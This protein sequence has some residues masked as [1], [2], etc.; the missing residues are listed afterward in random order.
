MQIDLAKAEGRATAA[1]KRL[2]RSFPLKYQELVQELSDWSE[3]QLH[4]QLEKEISL[5]QKTHHEE[6]KVEIE[7]RARQPEFESY[8]YE[9]TEKNIPGRNLNNSKNSFQPIYLPKLDTV[10]YS[11]GGR[12]FGHILHSGMNAELSGSYYSFDTVSFR[13]QDEKFIFQTGNRITI[14]DPYNV[15]PPEQKEIKTLVPDRYKGLPFKSMT[16]SH[17]AETG[18]LMNGHFISVVDLKNFTE[19]LT[20]Q[21]LPENILT[22]R[23]I[24][25]KFLVVLREAPMDPNN[26]NVKYLLEKIELSSKNILSATTLT[27]QQVTTRVPHLNVSED[28]STVTVSERFNVLSFN[29]ADLSQQ[30][31]ER[32]I[33]KSKSWPRPIR[34]PQL[35]SAVNRRMLMIPGFRSLILDFDQ[36]QEGLKLFDMTDLEILFDFG[37]RYQNGDGYQ[38]TDV[39]VEPHGKALV[40]FYVDKSEMPFMDIWYNSK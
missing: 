17:S 2:E 10:Y 3:A 31:V 9:L 24:E 34:P 37:K 22:A 40:V 32:S 8:V 11:D 25:D 33:F 18:L 36:Y 27:F 19:I 6:K 12:V 35:G 4:A 39:V 38:V 20:T 29:S 14:V 1:D 16:L 13:I 5:L 23:L 26:R 30:P 21:D 15:L 28:G 7:A